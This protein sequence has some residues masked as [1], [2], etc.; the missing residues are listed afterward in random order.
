MP[1]LVSGQSLILLS[2]TRYLLILKFQRLRV[3]RHSR[4]TQDFKFMRQIFFL[5]L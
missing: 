2:K 3:V 5:T 1:R 4:L